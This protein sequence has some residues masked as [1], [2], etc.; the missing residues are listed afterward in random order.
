MYKRPIYQYTLNHNMS[1]LMSTDGI[2]KNMCSHVVF[3][4]YLG[5]IQPELSDGFGGLSNTISTSRES[6][7]TGTHLYTP[8]WTETMCSKVPWWWYS[9]PHSDDYAIITQYKSTPED[10]QSIP[11]LFRTIYYSKRIFTW[12][13]CKQYNTLNRSAIAHHITTQLSQYIFWE[14]ACKK[15]Q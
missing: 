15:H 10:D 8:G 1:A 4:S 9:S 3:L 5:R 7:F 11:V 13:H 6:S 12:C 14:N 2:F